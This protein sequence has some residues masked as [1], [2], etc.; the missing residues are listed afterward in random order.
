MAFSRLNLGTFSRV[1]ASITRLYRSFHDFL[2][3]GHSNHE[4]NLY[5]FF[6]ILSQRCLAAWFGNLFATWFSREKHLFCTL[7]T[8]FKTFPFSL[9]HFLMFIVLS[10]HL[11]HKLTVF[12]LEKPPFFF[13]ISTSI[14][15]KRYGFSY[16]L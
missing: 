14:F 13:I 11:S 2:A 10:I 5:I 1:E 8:V 15:K 3:G 7:M 6:K 4:K 12:F 9:E 16:F